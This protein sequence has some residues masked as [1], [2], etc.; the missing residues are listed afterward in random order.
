MLLQT[1]LFFFFFLELRMQVSGHVQ[2]EER[3]LPTWR[4]VFLFG[5][6]AFMMLTKTSKTS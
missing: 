3:P 1:G 6:I 2:E 5:G 4:I